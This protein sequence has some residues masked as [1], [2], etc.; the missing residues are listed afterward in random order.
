[1]FQLLS[2]RTLDPLGEI[3]IVKKEDV[4]N[5]NHM[6]ETREDRIRKNVVVAVNHVREAVAVEIENVV[7][8]AG[9]EVEIDEVE[10]NIVEVFAF[11]FLFT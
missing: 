5:R 3:E 11:F 4:E 8:I 1:M 9:V 6:I 10:V 2:D 7:G